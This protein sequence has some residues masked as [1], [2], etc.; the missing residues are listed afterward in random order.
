MS[1]KLRLKKLEKIMNYKD[2]KIYVVMPKELEGERCVS[3]AGGERLTLEE[4][5][6]LNLEHE[7]IDC[8]NE[9]V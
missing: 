6:A 4:Y 7:T 9:G 1:N 2:R 5:E 3:V 8:F